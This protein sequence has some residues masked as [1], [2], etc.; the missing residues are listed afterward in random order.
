MVF[1]SLDRN[2]VR[3]VPYKG[4]VDGLTVCDRWTRR[5]PDS[6]VGRGHTFSAGRQ[7]VGRAG[8]GSR[9]GYKD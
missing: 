7:R 1:A 8:A 5:L 4:T 6:L 2:N 9:K 3:C